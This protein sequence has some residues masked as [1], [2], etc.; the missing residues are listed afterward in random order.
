MKLEINNRKKLE[1]FINMWK[2]NNVLQNN[3]WVKEKNHREKRKY[4]E[5]NEDKIQHTN[6]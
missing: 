2:L 6:L 5:M 4:I 1:K 3:Q